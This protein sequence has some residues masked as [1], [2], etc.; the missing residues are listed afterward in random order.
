[1]IPRRISNWKPVHNEEKNSDNRINRGKVNH[2]A[3]RK[4]NLSQTGAQPLIWSIVA[5]MPFLLLLLN[6]GGGGT[7]NVRKCALWNNLADR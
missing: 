2:S 4:I 3:Y 1:M 6:K 5:L 7:G